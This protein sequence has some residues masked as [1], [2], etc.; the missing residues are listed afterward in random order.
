MLLGFTQESVR[1]S[2]FCFD[3]LCGVVAAVLFPLYVDKFFIERARANQRRPRSFYHPIP[4]LSFSTPFVVFF[5]LVNPLS[6]T[7]ASYL[8][9]LPPSLLW[10]E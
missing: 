6:Y 3:P 4:F 1:F 2:F 8:P 7:S 5:I 9:P 10:L